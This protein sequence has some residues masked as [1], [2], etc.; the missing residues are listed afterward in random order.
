MYRGNKSRRTL[1]YLEGKINFL[2]IAELNRKAME[3]CIN[4]TDFTVE[5]IFAAD[6]CARAVV[7]ESI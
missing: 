5:D 4:K 2:Q 7:R 6:E 3:R 1:P